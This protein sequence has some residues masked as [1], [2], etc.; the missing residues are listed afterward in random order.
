MKIC[1]DAWLCCGCSACEAACPHSAVTMVEDGRGFY[2]PEVD[3]AKC[4]E[5]GLCRDVCP[6]NNGTAE[7][8]KRISLKVFAYKNSDDER[9]KSSSGAAFWALARYVLD[10]DGAVYGACFDDDF[11]VVHRRCAT[12]GEAQACRGSKYSQSFTGG[13]FGEAYEDLKQGKDVLYTGTP[14]QIAG[15]RSFLAKKSYAGQL[16]TCDLICHGTPSNRLF[17]E[18]IAFLERKSGK[19]VVGYCHRPKDRGWGVHVEKAT[20]DDGSTL[21]DTIE[22]N[23]WRDV[24]YSNDGLNPCCYRCLY[25]D[26]DRVAD[27]TLADFLGVDKC[28]ED[29]NDKKGLSVVMVNS[30]LAEGIVAQG[31]FEP[32]VTAISIDEVIPD[33]PMLRRPSEPRGDVEGF[34]RAHDRRGFEGAARYV[35]AYGFV[36]SV[37]VLA[38]RLMGRN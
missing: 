12:K 29:L 38:K 33:N 37:K 25:T 6:A 15:L 19:K 1:N 24:F 5:C 14:C 7:S 31:V 18:Y 22:S 2:R 30:E 4:V 20:M 11:R 16:V 17:R 26:V 9:A 3:E 10:S 8:L 36:R 35:G 23:T 32:G 27:F 34:W 21:Y 28:R 13:A